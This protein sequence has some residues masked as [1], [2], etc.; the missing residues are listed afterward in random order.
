MSAILDLVRSHPIERF[1]PGDILLEQNHHTGRLLVLLEGQV[2]VLRDGVRVGK[3]AE[4]GACF[5]EM[6]ALLGRAHTATVQ[7]TTA[8]SVA[9]IDNPRAFLAES[10]AAALHIAELL[11][12]RLDALNKYL[13]DVKSQYE[14]HDHLSMVDGVLETLMHRQPRTARR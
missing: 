7:A 8:G 13:I 12:R 11:A 1:Q 4:A 6:S 2:E 3:S 14:G 5:G 10:P 9:V